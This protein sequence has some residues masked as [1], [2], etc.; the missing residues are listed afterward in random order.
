ML[1]DIEVLRSFLIPVKTTVAITYHDSLRGFRRPMTIPIDHAEALDKYDPF[2][3]APMY[4]GSH[5][6]FGDPQWCET[7]KS[8]HL[9]GS[10]HRRIQ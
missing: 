4:A 6:P 8:W 5:K 10:S 9:L 1:P 3:Q 7:C 2:S